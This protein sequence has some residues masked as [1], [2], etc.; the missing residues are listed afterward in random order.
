MKKNFFVITR[1]IIAALGMYLMYTAVQILNKDKEPFNGAMISDE[2]NK[3]NI[4][5]T[6]VPNL[7]NLKVRQFHMLNN[8]QIRTGFIAQELLQDSVTKHFVLTD[9]AGYHQV[10]YIDLLVYEVTAQRRIIDSLIN[11]Q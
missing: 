4:D 9:D 11:N 1:L 8:D 5:S 3:E 2:R 6:F 10:L 7:L